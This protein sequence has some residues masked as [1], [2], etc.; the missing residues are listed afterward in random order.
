MRERLERD[1]LVLLV[2]RIRRA[3]GTEDEIEQW[4]GLVDQSVS[5]PSGYVS[6]LIFW[7]NLHGYTNEPSSTEIVDKAMSYKPIGL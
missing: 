2:E 4:L 6:D 1:Q 3:E 7:P 5:A